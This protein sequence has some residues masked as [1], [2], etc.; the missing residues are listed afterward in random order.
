MVRQ[1]VFLPY[2]S[3]KRYGMYG[4][5]QRLD[6][7]DWTDFIFERTQYRWIYALGRRLFTSFS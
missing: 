6:R 3:Q 5:A 1:N 2:L 4:I 7:I